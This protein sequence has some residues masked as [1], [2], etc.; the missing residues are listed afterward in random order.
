MPTQSTG[1]L[2]HIFGSMAMFLGIMLML[3][4]RDL[5]TRA[6]LLCGRVYFE[7]EDSQSWPVMGFLEESDCRPSAELLISSLA[8]ST[9]HAPRAFRCFVQATHARREMTRKVVNEPL[10]VIYQ[11]CPIEAQ[12]KVRRDRYGLPRG[13]VEISTIPPCP[14][15]IRCDDGCC[16]VLAVLP[17]LTRV[18][19][20]PDRFSFR[21]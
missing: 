7:S 21:T 13:E 14:K 9:C 11:L 18:R 5:A 19:L 16:T 8:L 15:V 10:R 3:C 17:D 20:L 2:M 1:M 4:S 6:H 12:M